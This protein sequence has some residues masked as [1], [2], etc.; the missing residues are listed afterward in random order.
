MMDGT[1]ALV[2]RWSIDWLNGRHLEVCEQILAPEYALLIGGFLLGP[3]TTYV[4]ATQEQFGRYPGLVVTT[5]QLVVSGD[6]VALWF[7]E[8]GA[9][10]RHGGRMAAW[11]GIAL[12]RGNGT[13][14]TH[15]YAEE[16][17][18]A[19]RRQLTAGHCNPIAPPAPAPWDAVPQP[20]DP[21]AEQVVR[22]WL[23]GA[24]P[25][26]GGVVFDDEP[27]GQPATGLLDVDGCAVTELFSAGEH[28]A[29]SVVQ[30]GRYAGGLDIPVDLVGQPM[31]LNVAGL[32]QVH[33]GA[34]VRGRVIR[35][36][37]GAA[38]ALRTAAAASQPARAAL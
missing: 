27:A 5:H 20:P 8:H 36:R 16:D 30:S 32:V 37:L 13:Q 2:R 28:V 15:C 34:V 12:F 14:L 9:S 33:G 7:T 22:G 26:T 1:V 4:P 18:Y 31:R 23:Q 11:S 25:C 24:D 38:R 19:R 21:A 35:D 3:R 6:R 17:Y 10:A 29:F